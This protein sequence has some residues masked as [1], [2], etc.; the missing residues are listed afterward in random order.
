MLGDRGIPNVMP[1]DEAR[2]AFNEE[3]FAADLGT[4]QVKFINKKVT[5]KKSNNLHHFL[6]EM[7]GKPNIVVVSNINS[8]TYASIR[9]EYIDTEIF[10][11]KEL[12]FHIMDCDIMSHHVVLSQAESAKVLEEYTKNKHNLP[13]ILTTDRVARHYNMQINQIC[14]IYRNSRVSGSSKCYRLVTRAPWDTLPNFE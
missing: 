8:K 13:R 6:D 4:H 9:N 7:I 2:D 12:L 1:P 3:T 11:A 5:T 14:A 10:F